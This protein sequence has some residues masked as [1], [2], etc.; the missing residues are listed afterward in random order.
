MAGLVRDTGYC[1]VMFKYL[2]LEWFSRLSVN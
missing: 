2:K 1:I